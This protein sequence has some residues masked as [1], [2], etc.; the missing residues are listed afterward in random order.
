M[1]I[2]IWQNKNKVKKKK[3]QSKQKKKKRTIYGHKVRILW[4]HGF[5]F[6][7]KKIN[8]LP[9]LVT[10]FLLGFIVASL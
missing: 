2:K 4:D 6:P 8:K 10:I 9:I 1:Y 5:A 7:K 3:N